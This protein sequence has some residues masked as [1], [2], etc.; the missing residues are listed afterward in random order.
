MGNTSVTRF[1]IP[2]IDVD[3]NKNIEIMNIMGA[4]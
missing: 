4:Y 2:G 1:R 3:W